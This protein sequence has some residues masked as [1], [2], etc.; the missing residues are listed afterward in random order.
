[1]NEWLALAVSEKVKPGPSGLCDLLA[2]PV[3]QVELIPAINPQSQVLDGNI[4]VKPGAVWLSITLTSRKKFFEEDSETSKAGTWYKQKITGILFGQSATNHLQLN[5][6]VYHRW[7]VLATERSTGL[8]Y[9][10]GKTPNGAELSI[11]YTNNASQQYEIEFNTQAKH[12]AWLYNNVGN[13]PVGTVTPKYGLIM[14]ANF[15]I[16]EPGRAVDGES[17]MVIPELANSPK[18]LLFIDGR[19]LAGKNYAD[20][21]DYNYIPSINKVD[22]TLPLSDKSVIQAYKLTEI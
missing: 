7:L 10:I 13:I 19:V 17:S 14:L 21:M 9:V 20:V 16:G 4:Q 2:I 18:I 3:E 8:T 1:M 11:K 6:W 12:R 15:R 5:N 22:T